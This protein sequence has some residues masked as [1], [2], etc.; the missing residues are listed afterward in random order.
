MNRQEAF[1]IV[2]LGL[3]AQGFRQSIVNGTCMYRGHGGRKCAAGLVIPDALYGPTMEGK[4]IDIVIDHT[5][6]LG[7]FRRLIPI[8]RDL[9]VIHD[10]NDNP[11]EMRAE[12]ERMARN[13]KLKIPV[14][15][16][17]ET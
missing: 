15:P 7:H 11:E 13:L 12:L 6:G 14:I 1:N 17:K 2:Y 10:E 3:A 4:S 8:L 9:Q 5:R 16:T